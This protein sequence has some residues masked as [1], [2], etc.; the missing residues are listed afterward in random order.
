M[1]F[2]L[3]PGRTPAYLNEVLVTLILKK[4]S[5]AADDLSGAGPAAGRRVHVLGLVCGWQPRELPGAFP[6][7][8]SP[9]RA[10]GRDLKYTAA[11]ESSVNV[12]LI[13]TGASYLPLKPLHP[14]L[15][16]CV[17]VGREARILITVGSSSW[18]ASF[19]WKKTKARPKIRIG[20][21]ASS[22]LDIM[23]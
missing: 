8:K 5:L 16:V 22:T 20:L 13:D 10:I 4:P 14:A 7:R 15:Q 1:I 2:I 3:Q 18:Y 23:G 9:G 17:C 19:T 21:S 12:F 6:R 11:P